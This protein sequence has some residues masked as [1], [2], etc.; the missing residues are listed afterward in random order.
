MRTQGVNGRPKGIHTILRFLRLQR[1]YIRGPI[2]RRDGTSVFQVGDLM[3][4]DAQLVE[5]LNRK[6]RLHVHIG[7]QIS[8]ATLCAKHARGLSD[9]PVVG[10]AQMRT[11]QASRD[12]LS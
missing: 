5:L 8:S 12:S 2:Q 7:S 3:L 9:E 11:A 4:T 6:E 1:I 10:P